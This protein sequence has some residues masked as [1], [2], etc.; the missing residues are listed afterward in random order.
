MITINELK[1][2]IAIKFNAKLYKV[3]SFE[4]VKPGKGAAFARVKLKN[5]EDGSVFEKTF[6]ASERI[7]DVFIDEKKMQYLYN[8]GDTYYFMDVETFEQV[9]I[10][11]GQL[12]ETTFFL[13]DNTEFTCLYAEGKIIGATPPIFVNLIVQD[14]DPG[15]RGNTAKGGTKSACLETGLTLQVPLFINQGDA[16]KVDTRTSKYV[17]RA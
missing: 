7:E 2:G 9:G 3:V 5:M 6:N 15:V 11:K 16:I 14:T 4:N 17:A 8:E 12:G 10:G 13:K 1:N